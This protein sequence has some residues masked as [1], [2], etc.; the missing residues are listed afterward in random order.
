LEVVE[1][2]IE[3]ARRERRRVISDL[4]RRLSQVRVDERREAATRR[5]LVTTAAAQGNSQPSLPYSL[6]SADR[7]LAPLTPAKFAAKRK[8][9]SPSSSTVRPEDEAE[10]LLGDAAPSSEG[11]VTGSA[12][13]AAALRAMSLAA[14]LRSDCG[15]GPALLSSGRETDDCETYLL[16]K[17]YYVTRTHSQISQF[18]SEVRRIPGV[19]STLRVVALG[20]RKQLCVNPDVKAAGSDAQI[21][22]KCRELLDHSRRSSAAAAPSSPDRQ[23]SGRESSGCPF[24]SDE[25]RVALLRDRV[26]A[27]ARDVEDAAQLGVGM[28]ACAY[29]GSRRAVAQAQIIALPYSMLLHRGTRAAMDL[30]LERC[31]VLFD[32]SHNLID[33]IN[34]THSA[35]LTLEQAMCAQTQ[36]TA[37][38]GRYRSR[39]SRSN[40]V[41][42]SQLVDVI[43]AFLRLLRSAS[44]NAAGASSDA[45]A[46]CVVSPIT[47]RGASM[48]PTEVSSGGS[49]YSVSN[50][51]Y[52]ASIDGVDLMGLVDYVERV[53]LLRK[54]RGFAEAGLSEVSGSVTVHPLREKADEVAKFGPPADDLRPDTPLGFAAGALQ[55]TLAFLSSLTNT[56]GDGRVILQSDRRGAF[57]KYALMNPAVHFRE[58]VDAARTVILAGGT[59]QPVDDLVSQLFGHLSA[60]RITRFACGHVIPRENLSAFAVSSGPCGRWRFTFDNRDDPRLIESLGKALLNLADVV[61]AGMVVFVP[62]YDYEARLMRAWQLHPQVVSERGATG[63][64]RAMMTVERASLQL[65]ADWEASQSGTVVVCGLHC[66]PGS[67]LARLAS[68]KAVFREPRSSSDV[69]SVMEQYAAAAARSSPSAASSGSGVRGAIIFAVVGAKFSEGINFSDDLARCVVVVGMPYPHKGN[70]ELQERMRYLDARQ[71]SHVLAPSSPS[72]TSEEARGVSC[73]GG[74]RRS[75]SSRAQTLIANAA[76]ADDSLKRDDPLTMMSVDGT[77]H[78]AS[79]ATISAMSP[80]SEY[81]ENLCLRAVNQSIGRAIRH[82]SDF[83]TIVLFDERYALPRIQRKLPGWIADRL[84]TDAGA[85]WGS[86]V[87][88]VASFFRQRKGR[89]AM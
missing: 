66:H 80:G 72:D 74:S 82:R 45:S 19:G 62:S 2:K 61:P 41:S 30:R 43:N 51:L 7:S 8:R 88:G 18:I 16:P 58:I 1:K 49:V 79:P 35:K 4:E 64:A 17:I 55:S 81:Y 36:L 77:V 50:F 65:R 73:V 23:Q 84:A 47:P 53:E 67:V 57:L 34:A 13:S 25:D 42:C 3:N 70:V 11:P 83:A 48:A 39:L 76:T 15:S 27:S 69:E 9:Q 33:S 26:L 6:V 46:S 24:I 32:E 5:A 60:S 20:S 68:R 52:R 59:L 86:V 21:N 89:D 38:L 78:D 63:S 54:L 44:L 37:Y 71:R 10:F 31:I 56:D 12:V 85:G 29:Y 14:E 40:L 87:A 28:G 22:E 75:A